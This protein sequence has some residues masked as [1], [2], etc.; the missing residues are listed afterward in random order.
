[1]TKKRKEVFVDVDGENIDKVSIE[2]AEEMCK[3]FNPY[4]NSN[5]TLWEDRNKCIEGTHTEETPPYTTHVYLDELI[6]FLQNVYKMH[7]NMPVLYFDAKSGHFHCPS[8][9]DIDILKKYFRIW[10]NLGGTHLAIYNKKALS[11]F[12]T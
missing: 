12:H 10:E 6:K 5:D 9:G 2:E 1:M 7:G 11:F 8:L 4:N 3:P